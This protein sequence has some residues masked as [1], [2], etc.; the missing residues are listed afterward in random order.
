MLS[1]RGGLRGCGTCP[2]GHRD[3]TIPPPSEP[4]PVKSG[5]ERGTTGLTLGTQT[6]GCLYLV[7]TKNH[8]HQAASCSMLLYLSCLKVT[9]YYRHDLRVVVINAKGKEETTS[10]GEV[11]GLLT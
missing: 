5:G 7:P 8:H 2:T 11:Q 1:P 3:F 9:L 4:Q 10:S 6:D